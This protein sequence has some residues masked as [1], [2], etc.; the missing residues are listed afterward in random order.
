MKA[1]S[2]KKNITAVDTN[3]F[4]KT[5]VVTFNNNKTQKIK[6]EIYDMLQT[7]SKKQLEYYAKFEETDVATL[8]VINEMLKEMK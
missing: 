6:K 1:K 8:A 4:L 2:N 7:M 3:T 5:T